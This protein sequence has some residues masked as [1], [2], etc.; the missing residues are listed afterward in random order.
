MFC[1]FCLSLSAQLQDV[2]LEMLGKWTYTFEDPQSGGPVTGFCTIKQNEGVTTAD[3]EL[4]Y[5][6]S[7]TSAFRPNENGKFYADMEVQSYPISVSFK[8]EG[9]LILCDLDA[10]SFVLPL[11]MKK[12]E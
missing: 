9:D 6:N 5:G 8:L 12:V 11:E 4:E 10:G 1:L 3:F 7:S 2:P